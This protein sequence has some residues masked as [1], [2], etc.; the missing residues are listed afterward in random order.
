MSYW[1][2][3]LWSFALSYGVAELGLSFLVARNSA[4]IRFALPMI[5]YYLVLCSIAYGCVRM[6]GRKRACLAFLAYGI[7]AEIY[8]FGNIKG[9]T[10]FPGMI[11]FGLLYLFMLGTPLLIGA[12]SAN[13]LQRE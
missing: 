6:F 3:L 2:Y 4:P 11:F 8:V 10:D 12:E 1:R 7:A 13:I 5:S 9:L